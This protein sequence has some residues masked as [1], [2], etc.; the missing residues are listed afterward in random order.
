MNRTKIVVILMMIV[1]LGLVCG[2]VLQEQL[3]KAP[4]ITPA[5]APPVSRSHASTLPVREG[6]CCMQAGKACTQTQD[7]V[8]CFSIGGQA[9]NVL[10]ANCDSY[11]LHATP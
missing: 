6:F 4:V 5:P 7:A 11:C 9:F 2:W 3:Q 1:L 8:G 10:Q